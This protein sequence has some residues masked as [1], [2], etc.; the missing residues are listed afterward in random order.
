MDTDE[1]I[2]ATYEERRPSVQLANYIEC[3]WT[4]ETSAPD[5]NH[6][7]LPDGCTDLLLTSPS[8]SQ[9]ELTVVGTMT[10]ARVFELPKG[11]IIGVRFRPGMSAGF[12]RVSGAEIVD[13]R[14]ALD[15]IWGA[16]ARHLADLLVDTSFAS[17]RIALLEEQLTSQLSDQDA[18]SP[19][20]RALLWAEQMRGCVSVDELAYHSGLSP[21]QL[22]RNCY[23]LTGLTPK[24][25]CRALRFR[26][27][28][29]KAS[30]AERGQWSDLALDCGYYD[31]AHFIHDFR[32]F[33]GFTPSDYAE[34][35]KIDLRHV[36]L[37]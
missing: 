23:E 29:A 13:Q 30:S 1:Q 11:Q 35:T 8:D 34:R 36:P 12:V 16:R 2:T 33:S 32:S 6:R 27:A 37:S 15:D 4:F 28:A 31:Q 25:L 14:V 17:A 22:R 9:P 20:Q 24:Q 26:H 21:R 7:V 19:T 10:S 18:L 3:F 5:S